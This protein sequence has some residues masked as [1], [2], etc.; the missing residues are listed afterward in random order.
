[1]MTKPIVVVLLAV[2]SATPFLCQAAERSAP[3][4]RGAVHDALRRH[5]TT[6]GTEQEA[7]IR[8]LV[9]L[10][11]EVQA[12]TKFSDRSRQQLSGLVR[13]RLRRT[14]EALAKQVSD[15]SVTPARNGGSTSLS[16]P[17]AGGNSPAQRAI[18]AQ[19]AGI[20]AGQK[21]L[22]G[23]AGGNFQP[24]GGAVRAAAGQAGGFEAATTQ[25]AQELVDLIQTTIAPKSWQ[26]N[27]GLGSIMYFSPSRI[28]VIRQTDGIHTK[29]GAALN[30]MR[31]ASLRNA[32]FE[33]PRNCSA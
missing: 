3:A 19:N 6:C 5:A 17:A 31:G 10:Y 2:V 24:P 22:A 13:N 18:L 30:E 1:M 20:A 15:D 29:V 9:A 23:A 11:R 27:G 7:T 26:A 21:P 8:Q 28:L 32:Q 33:R 14:Q 16:E 25:N 12:S 4:L